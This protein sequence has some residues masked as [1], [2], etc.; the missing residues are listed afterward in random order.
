[1]STLAENRNYES[2]PLFINASEEEKKSFEDTLSYAGT[3]AVRGANIAP[4][5]GVMFKV[6][7]L[8]KKV[9]ILDNDKK[10]TGSW[11]RV[12]VADS[13]HE[14]EGGISLSRLQGHPS[15][16]FWSKPHKLI[17]VASNKVLE[18]CGAIVHPAENGKSIIDVSNLKP[19]WS[20]YRAPNVAVIALHQL[21]EQPGQY[22]IIATAVVVGTRYT[23][24]HSLILKCE[25]T[26]V[27]LPTKR[28]NS[29]YGS[30]GS[31]FPLNRL[32]GLL[33][34]KIQNKGKEGLIDIASTD[35][36]GKFGV[37]AKPSSGVHCEIEVNLKVEG[38]VSI[39]GTCRNLQL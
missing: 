6:S 23:T 37:S 34:K 35:I 10:K 38:P 13:N 7:G 28:N 22:V 32:Q 29:D 14:Y 12:P 31:C 17:E 30:E 27:Q 15:K 20:V 36:P 9:D 3:L 39:Y 8:P 2:S 25:S 33:G 18:V 16:S 4:D 24:K 11:I 26:T 19:G 1:M 21:I 5:A